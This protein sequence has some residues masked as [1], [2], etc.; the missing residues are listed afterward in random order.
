MADDPPDCT[1]LKVLEK[2]IVV[3]RKCP[4]LVHFRE[5][6]PP[7]PIYQDE[8]YWRKPVPGF[9]DPNAWLLIVGLAPASHGG[10][11]T[12]RI[13]TGDRSAQFL[14]KALY[15]EG[16]CNQPTSTS[17]DDGLTYKNCYLTA[18]VKCAP[19]HDKPDR[20]ECLNCNVY[21][22]NELK[23]LK[24]LTH[25]LVLGKVAFDGFLLATKANRK[26]GPAVKFSHG[27]KYIFEDLPIVYASYHPSPQNT[28][29][30]V[31]S[32]QMFRDL[33]KE[34]KKDSKK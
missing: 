4:R 8:T 12:G 9:G 3:C 24:N 20:S 34:I 23:L 11:R 27:G 29:T 19:P 17:R 2:H 15:D 21:F 31:L 26:K 22:Q 7:K 30:G 13:F 16:F 5:T 14:V 33:L 28:N 1:S 10:N 6:V 32:E 25:V 18:V